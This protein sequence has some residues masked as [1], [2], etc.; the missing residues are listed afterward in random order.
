MLIMAAKPHFFTIALGEV[1]PP[2]K[3]AALIERPLQNC[4]SKKNAK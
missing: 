3:N 4:C 1:D 2:G